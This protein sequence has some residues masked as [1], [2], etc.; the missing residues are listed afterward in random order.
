MQKNS[1]VGELTVRGLRRKT[2]EKR[3]EETQHQFLGVKSSE[4]DTVHF[5]K[6]LREKI[7]L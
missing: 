1:V 5:Q 7:M 4:T 2:V 3:G 6:K